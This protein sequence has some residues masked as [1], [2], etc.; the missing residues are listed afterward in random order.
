MTKQTG[1]RSVAPAIGMYLLLIGVLTIVAFRTER[2][3]KFIT[4]PH[5]QFTQQE[6][7]RMRLTAILGIIC[8]TGMV[9][10]ILYGFLK[11]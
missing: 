7:F 10:W 3:L 11:F 1:F 2:A 6:L 4:S 9:S 8:F 5:R